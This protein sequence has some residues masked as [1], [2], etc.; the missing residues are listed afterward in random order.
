MTI[1]LFVG[2]FYWIQLCN[3]R[4]L[5]IYIWIYLTLENLVI[6]DTNPQIFHSYFLV[7]TLN[8][9]PWGGIVILILLM[10]KP[11]PREFIMGQWKFQWP[12]FPTHTTPAGACNPAFPPSLHVEVF[13]IRVPLFSLLETN[14]KYFILNWYEFSAIYVYKIKFQRVFM[15]AL[16]HY[17]LCLWW[18][19]KETICCSGNVL[20]C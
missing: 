4:N 15:A 10:R 6:R 11:K 3:K 2:S 9:M 19:S 13:G 7:F 1:A 12:G 17:V 5:F 8:G 14:V 20:V 16:I 18:V